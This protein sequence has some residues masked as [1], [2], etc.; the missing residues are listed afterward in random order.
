MGDFFGWLSSGTWS[1]T[2]HKNDYHDKFNRDI[3]IFVDYIS[4]IPY[5]KLIGFPVAFLIIIA[6]WFPIFA[7]VWLEFIWDSVKSKF[8]KGAK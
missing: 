8:K 5:F 1:R 3:D 4:Q 6:E 7:V 2:K